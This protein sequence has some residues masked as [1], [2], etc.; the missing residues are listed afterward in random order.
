VIHGEN[1]LDVLFVGG[2]PTLYIQ[3]INKILTSRSQVFV[4][5]V[6][7]TTNGYFAK[8]LFSAKKVLTSFLKLDSVQLSFDKFHCKF[9]PFANVKYLSKACSDLGIGFSV[10]TAIQDPMD[11]ILLK[12]LWALGRIKVG[13]SKV[14]PLGSAKISKTG[15]K[16]PSFDRSVLMRKCPGRDNLIYLGS[17]GFTSCCSM[18]TRN[19]RN[20]ALFADTIAEFYKKPFHNLILKNNFRDLIKRFGIHLGEPLPEWSNPCV[21][22]GQIFSQ[23]G[24]RKWLTEN[25][26]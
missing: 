23:P 3:D 26:D 9:L 25:G 14:L 13:I 12:K 11:L 19:T 10:L 20:T 8:T 1:F 22:C 4:G 6:A 5:R 24:G 21:I 2:E 15:M 7:I 18:L 16:Y 17:K